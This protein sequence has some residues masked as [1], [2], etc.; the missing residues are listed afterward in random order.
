MNTTYINYFT[1]KIKSININQY[2]LNNYNFKTKAFIMFNSKKFEKFTRYL[3]KS[4]PK[5]IHDLTYDL[6]IKIK[7][8]LKEQLKRINFIKKDELD[9]QTQKLSKI[10]KKIELLEEKIKILETD[11]NKTH[12]Y[13]NNQKLK[14]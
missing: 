2:K 8:I 14:K 9:L 6:D 13:I 11:S 10:Q 5:T 1:K 4:I 12:E 3:N 7:T